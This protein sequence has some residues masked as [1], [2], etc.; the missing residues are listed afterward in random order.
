MALPVYGTAIGATAGGGGGGGITV[1]EG[2]YAARPASP[3]VGDL[4]YSTDLR[5]VVSRCLV[6]GAWVDFAR[7]VRLSTVPPIGWSWNNQTSGGATATL[8]TPGPFQSITTPAPPLSGAHFRH[9][10]RSA[11]ATPWKLTAMFDGMGGTRTVGLSLR[12]SSSDKFY[13]FGVSMP[14]LYFGAALYGETGAGPPSGGV[15]KGPR[16]NLLPASGPHIFSIEDDGSELIFRVV[17]PYSGIEVEHYRESRTAYMAGGP[18]E[19]GFHIGTLEEDGHVDL[20][21]WEVV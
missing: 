16:T 12:E 10:V 11:P 3:A 9:R 19:F 13:R 17:H 5:G 2:T 20:I 4:H 14:N 15:V 6:A 8:S 18:D 1:T 21:S 7:D